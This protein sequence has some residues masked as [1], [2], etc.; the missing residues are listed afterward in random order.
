MNQKALTSALIYG[1]IAAIVAAGIF[2]LVNKYVEKQA[3]H[4]GY[5]GAAITGVIALIVVGAIGYFVGQ[6]S[7]NN[8]A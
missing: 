6:S 2:E 4:T 3:F 7:G 8:P 5:V 1:V